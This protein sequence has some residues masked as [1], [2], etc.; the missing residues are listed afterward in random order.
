MWA[1]FPASPSFLL[2]LYR[3]IVLKICNPIHHVRLQIL[4][5]HSVCGK[6]SNGF[7]FWEKF[8]KLHILAVSHGDIVGW[9]GR[10]HGIWSEKTLLTSLL[11]LVLQ[12]RKIHIEFRECQ[13]YRINHFTGILYRKV[14]TPFHRGYLFF[15]SFIYIK[16]SHS[17]TIQKYAAILQT[18]RCHHFLFAPPCILQKC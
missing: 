8:S 7:F 6:I 4:S 9:G 10:I 18:R 16:I 11:N 14:I 12:Q 5:P 3:S 17:L 15:S 1:S 2:T 13:G